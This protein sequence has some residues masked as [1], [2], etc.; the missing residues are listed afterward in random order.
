MKRVAVIIVAGGGGKRMGEGLPKQFRMLGS[1][2]ILAHTINRFHRALPS[3]QLIV[4]L[5]EAHIAF[6]ENLRARFEVARHQV[7]AGGTERFHSVK[8]GLAA[9]GYDVELVAVQDGV[10][11]LASET[12][13]CRLVSEAEQFATAIPVVEAVDS[14]RVVEGE[15]SHIIDRRPLRIVQTPQVFRRALL[16]EAYEQPFSPLFTDDASVVEAMGTAVHLAAG[17]RSNLKIT[18]PEDMILARALLD[19]ECEEQPADNQ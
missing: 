4:V 15:E 9:V 5:P 3:A 6:W 7:V 2:P 11:P 16:D 10:R 1:E 8:N 19:A 17:E 12:M 14:Y 18:T 13:I